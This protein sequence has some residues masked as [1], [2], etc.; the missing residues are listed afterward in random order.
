[1]SSESLKYNLIDTILTNAPLHIGDTLWAIHMSALME[2]AIP[3]HTLSI[4]ITPWQV[5]SVYTA[6]N[7]GH[8]TAS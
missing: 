5:D 4:A 6:T 8:M 1:M 7:T 2:E 3:I